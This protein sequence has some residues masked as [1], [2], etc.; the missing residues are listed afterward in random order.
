MTREFRL[1]PMM[2]LYSVVGTLTT[3]ALLIASYFLGVDFVIIPTAIGA[4]LLMAFFFED[5]IFAV[6]STPDRTLLLS[7]I[8]AIALLIV[9]GQLV[10]FLQLPLFLLVVIILLLGLRQKIAP[11]HI[12]VSLTHL[13]LPSRYLEW[14]WEEFTDI[15]RTE[16]RIALYVDDELVF[17]LPRVFEREALYDIIVDQ[18]EVPLMHRKLTHLRNGAVINF[19]NLKLTS[20]LIVIGKD[21]IPVSDFQNAV[22]DL[23]RHLTIYANNSVRHIDVQH[24]VLAEELLKEHQDTDLGNRREV[25][26]S[27]SPILE[28]LLRAGIIWRPPHKHIEV[29][30]DG[31]VVSSPRSVKSWRWEDFSEIKTS[32]NRTLLMLNGEV[33]ADI[34]RLLKTD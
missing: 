19:P 25:I 23:W 29:Y 9:I 6:T 34:P 20:E 12:E 4:I 13:R 27:R 15:R 31:L 1:D 22:L 2:R 18:V 10:S 33:V 8:F 21:A 3:I 26:V 17:N 30:D 14:R 11:Q 32:N 7:G 5:T 16:T 24:Y 28:M